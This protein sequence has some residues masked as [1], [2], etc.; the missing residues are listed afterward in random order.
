MGHALSVLA[1]PRKR[2]GAL[3]SEAQRG[4]IKIRQAYPI[5][6]AEQVGA[7]QIIKHFTCR[8]KRQT[9]NVQMQGTRAQGTATAELEGARQNMRM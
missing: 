3:V 7:K 8:T 2:D 1:E 5:G 9:E 4:G 6:T